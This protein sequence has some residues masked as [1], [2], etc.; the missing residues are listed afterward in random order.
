MLYRNIATIEH[1][2]LLNR[3]DKYILLEIAQVFTNNLSRFQ[4][5]YLLFSTLSIIL[6]K[7][8]DQS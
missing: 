8:I 7:N 6:Q 3:V 5:L 4:I 2:P 1:K